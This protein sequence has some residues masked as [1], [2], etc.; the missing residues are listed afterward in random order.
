MKVVLPGG[1][2][3]ATSQH[4]SRMMPLLTQ[5]SST[6]R[7][8]RRSDFSRSSPFRS[9]DVRGALWVSSRSTPRAPREFT[10]EE[11]E[12]LVTSSSLVAGA[13]ENA[14]LHAETQR[15]VRQLELL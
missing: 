14:R 11:V 1:R 5:G 15:R 6:Y 10:A 9:W 4:S 12:F 7:S 2:S 13:I 8:W 3:S